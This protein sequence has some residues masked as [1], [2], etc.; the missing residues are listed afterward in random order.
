MTMDFHAIEQALARGADQQ[1]GQYRLD[2]DTSTWW[3][4]SQT[5]QMHGFE[6]GEVVPTTE[7]IL[8]HKHP[9]DRDRVRSILQ[10]A[11][12]TGE[13]FSSVHRIMDAHGKERVLVIVGQGRR[14]RDT[15]RVRE[16]MG[17]FVDVTRTVQARAHDQAHDHIRAAAA[18]RGP[19]E[20]A[21]GIITGA[22]GIGPEDSFQILKRC[23][24]DK[25]VAL[26]DLAQLVVDEATHGRGG[27]DHIRQ[28][29]G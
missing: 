12:R 5:Y 10:E 3:W 19:I 21:K 17:Y 29:L 26:R 28:L 16:L 25:N 11:R 24:N 13:P 8:A 27:A 9:D 23:S 4:S 1:I 22:L 2:L 7:L 14:D 15:G 18:T 20:Q 6:P